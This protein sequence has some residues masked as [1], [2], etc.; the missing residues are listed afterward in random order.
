MYGKKN[1][2][3]GKE[4]DLHVSYRLKCSQKLGTG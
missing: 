4:H 3:N 2:K 1:T